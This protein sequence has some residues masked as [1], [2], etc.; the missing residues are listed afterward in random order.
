MNLQTQI[1]N[2]Y[3]NYLKERNKDAIGVMRVILAEMQRSVKKDLT[4]AEVISILKSLKKAAIESSKAGSDNKAYIELLD[5]YLP[6][7]V[8]DEEIE[9][10]VKENVDFSKYKNKMAAMREI[11]SHFGDSAEGG[12]VKD[13]LI[14]KF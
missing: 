6:K 2:D 4:D 8:S 5:S 12:R 3:K 7:Q 11:M 13:I 10:W 1:K 9:H 14:N